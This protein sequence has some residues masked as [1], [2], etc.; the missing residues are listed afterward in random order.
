MKDNSKYIKHH[1]IKYKNNL[2]TLIMAKKLQITNS[3]KSLPTVLDKSSMTEIVS[4]WIK[5]EIPDT[6]H[7][8][9]SHALL[10]MRRKVIAING[11]FLYDSRH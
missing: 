2:K 8:T 9:L 7:Y 11:A 1:Y 4:N 5:I 3:L 6:L 10:L